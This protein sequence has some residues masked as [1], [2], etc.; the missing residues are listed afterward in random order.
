MAPMATQ[1]R[2]VCP[3]D[4]QVAMPISIPEAIEVF[5]YGFCHGKSQTYPY[6]PIKV[7]NLW[8]MRDDPPRK[9]SRKTEVI[10]Y[11]QSPE[12]TVVAIQQAELGWHF[13]CHI[14]EPD[15]DY[16]GIRA[17]YKELG[18]R[19]ISTEGLFIH[20]LKNIPNYE[21]D[22][23]A[24]E[25]PNQETWQTIPQRASQANKLRP[26]TWLFGIWDETI[27]YG[28]VTSVPVK[29]FAWV[30]G[31]YVHQSDRGKGYGRALMTKL[32]ASDREHGITQSVLLASSDGA[33][34]YPHLGYQKIGILQMFCPTKREE[35]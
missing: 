20:D 6:V 15:D 17:K 19:A 2:R 14:H 3:D 16:D 13:L 12:E 23:P 1:P 34:L 11:G 18:Y 33:R 25:I 26:D 4:L 28:W 30:S 31:L 7:G 8:V 5:V 27:D 21:S 29:D 22:P 32:L 10:T 9:K 24:R 35:G